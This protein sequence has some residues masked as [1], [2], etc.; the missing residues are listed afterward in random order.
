MPGTATEHSQRCR[1]VAWVATD[2]CEL[3]CVTRRKRQRPGTVKGGNDIDV[4]EFAGTL[5][6][7]ERCC[8]VFDDFDTNFPFSAHDRGTHCSNPADTIQTSSPAMFMHVAS[9]TMCRAMP[10]GPS[11]A[12]RQIPSCKDI[13]TD[14]MPYGQG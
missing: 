7:D 10:A 8:E 6:V 3:A 2:V 11:A 4:C 5:E 12:T 13:S 9:E 1:G 14:A